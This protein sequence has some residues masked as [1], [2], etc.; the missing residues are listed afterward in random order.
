MLVL[1]LK[2]YG[3]RAIRLVPDPLLQLQGAVVPSAILALP[4]HLHPRLLHPR[5]LKH[6][7]GGSF[8]RLAGATRYQLAFP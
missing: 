5:G 7:G 6:K 1:E 8:T 4:Q 3:E 2:L